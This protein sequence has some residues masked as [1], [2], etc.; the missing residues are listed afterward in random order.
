MNGESHVN[1]K[2]KLNYWWVEVA[3][4]HVLIKELMNELEINNEIGAK[5]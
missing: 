1:Y 4:S 3:S 5:I 2:I